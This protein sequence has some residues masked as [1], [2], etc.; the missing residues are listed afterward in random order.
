MEVS[1]RPAS[2]ACREVAQALNADEAVPVPKR[3]AR[4]DPAEVSRLSICSALAVAVAPEMFNQ[5]T[6][7]KR[8]WWH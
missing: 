4:R 6:C 2:R 5:S 7:S 8:N 1:G 3:G